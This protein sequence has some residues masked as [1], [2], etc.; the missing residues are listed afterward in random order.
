MEG[1]LKL[2]KA[3]GVLKRVIRSGWAKVGVENPESVAEHSYRTALLAMLL[4]DLEG[5]N[6]ERAM[7]MALLHDLAESMTGDLTPEE[8]RRLGES[9]R[10]REE[11]AMRHLLR[12]LPEGLRRRYLELWKEYRRCETPEARLVHMA[13]GL[14]MVLQALEYEE[15]G[16]EAK[17]LDRFWRWKGEGAASRLYEL[18]RRKRLGLRA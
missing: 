7:R 5:F 2:L 9:Y 11:E 15:E 6:A 16:I 1:L 14:E 3:A 12:G 10:M 17:R 4:A 18:L 13:D 8:K